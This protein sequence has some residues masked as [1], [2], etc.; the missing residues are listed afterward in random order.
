VAAL[1]MLMLADQPSEQILQ[2]LLRILNFR[3]RAGLS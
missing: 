2:L 3:G 1:P